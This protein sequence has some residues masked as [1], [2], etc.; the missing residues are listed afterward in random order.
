M[1]KINLMGIPLKDMFLR[2]S[3][4]QVEVFL[5]NGA[6]NS[7]IYINIPLLVRAKDDEEISNWI[8]QADITVFGDK[9]ILKAC[10]ITARNRIDE[11]QRLVFLTTLLGKISYKRYSVFLISDS[12]KGLEKI[13]SDLDTIR[14]D[15]N[16]VGTGVYGTDEDINAGVIN[17]IN[18]MVPRV[19]IMRS[20]EKV[21]MQL[22]TKDRDMINAEVIIYLP[23]DLNIASR[24]DSV[25]ERFIQKIY[26]RVFK[27]SASQ[28]L[29][30]IKDV[31]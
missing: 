12:D 3:L 20:S 15:L 25:R 10:G 18:S 26:H 31:H 27:K 11:A 16:I 22:M 24:K 5:K 8:Q 7:V 19:I 14:S 13:Q 30:S 17:K 29:N 28:Y 21:C 2:E 6:L 1:K 4:Q 9:D 23:E